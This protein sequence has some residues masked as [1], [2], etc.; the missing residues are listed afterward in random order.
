LF[1]VHRTGAHA[2]AD[3]HAEVL[4]GAGNAGRRTLE[5]VVH[6][7]HAREDAVDDRLLLGQ[8]G[9]AGLGDPIELLGPLG[10]LDGDVAELLEQ[11]QGGIDDAW[12]GL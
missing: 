1:G 12:L 2:Q 9:L 10:G 11:G 5:P 6:V 8:G 3:G 7:G 4:H